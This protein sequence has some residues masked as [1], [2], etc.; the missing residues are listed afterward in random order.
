M[1]RGIC[2]LLMGRYEQGWRDYHA[3]WDFPE[4][5]DRNDQILGPIWIGSESIQGKRILLQSE[6]GLGDTIQF[7]RYAK[8][9]ADQGAEVLLSVQQRH[10][11]D[12]NRS[13][14]VR[15]ALDASAR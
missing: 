14:R 3:R 12:R 4:F 6:Q 10:L 2:L 15:L 11:N 8:L 7:C 5:T 9:V 13:E 1:N